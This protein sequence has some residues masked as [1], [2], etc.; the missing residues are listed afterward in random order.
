MYQL[1]YR[2][3]K[4]KV[5]KV[6]RDKYGCDIPADLLERAELVSWQWE[7]I[8]VIAGSFGFWREP[9]DDDFTVHIPENIDREPVFDNEIDDMTEV[10]V[11]LL[12]ELLGGDVVITE[13]IYGDKFRTDLAICEIDM[14]ALQ[15]R[16]RITDGDVRSLVDEWKFLKGYRFLRTSDPMTYD[17]FAEN[18]PY[19]NASENRTVWNRLE[20]M[21]LLVFRGDYGTVVNVPIHI[22]AHAVELKQR[23]WEEAYHQARR[24]ALPRREADSY[25]KIQRNPT[26]YGYAD[27]PWVVMDAGHI[28]KALD[29]IEQ[30]QNGHVGLIGLTEGSAVK[31]V[32]PRGFSPPERSLDRENLNEKTIQAMD[33]EDFVDLS[34]ISRQARLDSI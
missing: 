33:I 21:G 24:A 19:S 14:S 31:F 15:K 7:Q 20:D 17:E 27:Y 28:D 2:G 25:F 26:R 5:K 29:N 34:S 10:A 6:F 8:E 11:E 30:F 22:T 18:G 32:E 3:S 12:P 9:T 13:M 23:D 16:M 4:R 1:G